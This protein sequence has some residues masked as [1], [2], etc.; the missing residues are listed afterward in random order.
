LDGNRAVLHG[1][2]PLWSGVGDPFLPVWT[3]G[4]YSSAGEKLLSMKSLVRSNSST[5]CWVSSGLK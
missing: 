1:A 4:G 2:T 3:L 5:F